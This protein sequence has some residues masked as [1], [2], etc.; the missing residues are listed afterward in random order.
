MTSSYGLTTKWPVQALSD[1]VYFQEGPG[2]RNW[3][4]R[5][6]G[7]PF[8]NIRC[9]RD[10]R[11]LR[12]DMTC[13][14][15]SE[16]KEKYEH[17][18]LDAGDYVVSS[19]GTLGRLAEVFESDLPCML[20]TS[21]IRFRPK[22]HDSIDRRYLR[23]FLTSSYFEQQILAFANGS[24]QLNY[25]PSHLKRMGIVVPPKNIQ[26]TI[27]AALGALD[28]RIK[29]LR[30]TNKTIENIA[31]AIFKAWFVD[32]EPVRNKNHKVNPVANI[33][34]DSLVES[35][36]GLIPEGWRVMQV[37]DAIETYGGTTPDTKNDAYWQP[38]QYH[39]TSPKDLSGLSSS[40]LLDTEKKVSEAGLAKVSSGLLPKGT[41][42]LSSRAPIG[43]LAITQ[44]PIAIN[45]GY[46]AMTP[47]GILSPYFMLMWCKCNMDVIEGR[48]NGS[49][50]MEISKKAFRPIPILVPADN[51]LKAFDEQVSALFDEVVN[52]EKQIKTLTDIRDSLL[53]RMLSGSLAIEDDLLD[54]RH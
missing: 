7:I 39:W 2:L 16:V 47:G 13:L 44:I 23:Y 36:L 29:L 51:V 28:D 25:G 22:S 42:L 21:V 4:Y 24:A 15:E 20:N 41:L 27:G 19:S 10:G 5:E 6:K 50:F 8:V 43:Y 18:L 37:G 45:Q 48:A 34:P 17:F 32:F 12:S 54:K 31:Y 11:L 9:I 38:Q 14:D 1:L 49:T 35:D 33:F 26:N 40:V 30:E 52:N 3:Q 53:P 46:I